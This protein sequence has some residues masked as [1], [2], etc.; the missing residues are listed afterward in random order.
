MSTIVA[1]AR[2]G[3]AGL[4]ADSQLAKI[5]NRVTEVAEEHPYWGLPEALAVEL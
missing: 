1:V 4:T 5:G 3:S 2:P